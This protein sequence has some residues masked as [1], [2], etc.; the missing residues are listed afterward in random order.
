MKTVL[1]ILK[2]ES[3]ATPIEYGVVVGLGLL[4]GFLWNTQ[5]G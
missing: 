3:G 4:A 1:L 2:D 5:Y